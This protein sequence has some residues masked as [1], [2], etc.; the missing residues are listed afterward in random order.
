MTHDDDVVRTAVGKIPPQR[1]QEK[2]LAN[3]AIKRALPSWP[4]GIELA[5][6]LATVLEPLPL[7]WIFFL[8]LGFGKRARRL[9]GT[10]VI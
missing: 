5:V 3:L 7:C 2:P 4:P 1:I 6:E 9:A 8:Y 10:V